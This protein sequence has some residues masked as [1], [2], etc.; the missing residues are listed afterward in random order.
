MSNM[1]MQ[2][3]I[4]SNEERGIARQS[5]KRIEGIR[6]IPKNVVLNIEGLSVQLPS[7]AVKLVF[8]IL[9]EMAD[10]NSLTLIP[11]HA[12]LTT[13]EGADMLN[14]S[15]PYFVKLLEEGKIPFNKVGTRRRVLASDVQVYMSK[16]LAESDKALQELID[17]AQELNMGY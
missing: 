13:Q 16:S 15:R 7:S 2:I 5:L 17:Q 14:V 11:S 12:Y 1:S 3:K 8:S 4:P 6:R 9:N 10:G